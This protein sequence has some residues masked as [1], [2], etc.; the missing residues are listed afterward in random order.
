MC[1]LFVAYLLHEY[2]VK[3][4]GWFLAHEEAYWAIDF[5]APACVTG[6]MVWFLI[7][8]QIATGKLALLRGDSTGPLTYSFR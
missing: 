5:L 2:I 6:N 8:P 3:L 7:D 1:L 4:H